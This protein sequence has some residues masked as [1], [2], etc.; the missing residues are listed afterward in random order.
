[1]TAQLQLKIYGRVQGVSFRVTIQRGAKNLGLT[2]LVKNESDGSVFVLAQG[3]EKKLQEL[4]ISCHRGNK[5]AQVEKIHAVWSE[6]SVL[7][8]GFDVQ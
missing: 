4:L 7:W 8:N 6:T 3:D 1:M 5:Y 2:G